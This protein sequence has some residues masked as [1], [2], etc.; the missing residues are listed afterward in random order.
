MSG[1][2]LGPAFENDEIRERLTAAG[3]SFECLGD[4]GVIDR[5]AAALADEKAIGWFQGRMEFGP[6]ALGNRSIIA[7]ARS[8]AMQRT[9]NLKVK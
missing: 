4:D 7:D 5:T 6:R 3:A 1:S 9:L 8:P 2:Y